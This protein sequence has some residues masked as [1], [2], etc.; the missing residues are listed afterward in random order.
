ML[1]RQPNN[2]WQSK[3]FRNQP[4]LYELQIVNVLKMGVNIYLNRKKR[5]EKKR[6]TSKQM[7]KQ[8]KYYLYIL[9]VN[10]EDWT[11]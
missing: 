10:S 9:Y 2:K 6:V 11:N 3:L 8:N 1:S 7:K 5:N 4:H